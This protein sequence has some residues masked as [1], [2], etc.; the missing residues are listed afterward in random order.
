[1]EGRFCRA[2]LVRYNE[3][4]DEPWS[5]EELAHKL[6]SALQ[7]VNPEY[8]YGCKAGQVQESAKDPRRLALDFLAGTAW[9]YWNADFWR[10][11]GTRYELIAEGEVRLLLH[12]RV[13]Q[14]LDADYAARLEQSNGQRPPAPPSVTRGLVSDALE[15]VKAHVLRRGV[16]MPWHFE[17]NKPVHLLAVQNGLLDP[18]TDTLHGHTPDYFSAACLPFEYNAEATCPKWLDMLEKNLEGDAERIALLQEFFGYCLLPTT[19]AQ[20][21]LVLVGEGGNGKSVVLAGLH[22]LLGDDNVSSVPLED[23]A[24]RFALIQTLGKLANISAEIGEL[25]KT[26]EGTFKKFVAGDLMSFERK[27]KDTFTARPT[28]RLVLATNNLPY[29][30][31]KTSGIWR[32]LLIVPFLRRV[33]EAERVAGMDKAGWWLDQGEVPGILVWALVGLKRL[34]ANNWKFTECAAS[35]ATLAGHRLDCDPT[36]AFLDEFY[37]ADPEAEAVPSADVYKRYQHWCEDSG[38]KPLSAR[39]FAV[40]VRR[41]FGLEPPQNRRWMGVVQKC[42]VGL[43]VRPV[44]DVTECYRSPDGTVTAQAEGEKGIPF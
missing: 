5:P 18:A 34:L 22:A 23:F 3:R 38:H 26:A 20:A 35:A 7:E 19:D 44:T 4:L 32:R 42:W 14:C 43:A 1:M 25:D 12:S 9:V 24:G 31:D 10:Y 29:F 15:S 39:S 30:A 8:P 40:Q 16:S 21:C 13:Q 37:R 11:D 41:V 36:R 2:V 17:Q 28:A 33:P 27:G 6:E